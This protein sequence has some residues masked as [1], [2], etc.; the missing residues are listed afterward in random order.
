MTTLELR[1]RAMRELRAIAPSMFG[2]G[3]ETLWF[4]EAI[5]EALIQ[6]YLL[7]YVA[8]ERDRGAS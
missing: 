6:A 2:G 8:A 7:G 1:E 3:A 4:R 5:I